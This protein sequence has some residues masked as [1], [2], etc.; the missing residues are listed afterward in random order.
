MKNIFLSRPNWIHP[1]YKEGLDNFINLLKSQDLNPRTIGTTDFPSK[2]PMDEVI[3]LLYQCEGIIVLGYPQIEMKSGFVKDSEIIPSIHLC[4]EWN[5]IET[6]LAYSLGL[7]LLIIHDIKITR[8]IFDRGVLN[9]FL[10]QKDFS[11]NAWGISPDVIGAITKWKT[12]LKAINK[13]IK[14]NVNNETPVLKWGCFKF[15]PDENLYCPFCYN[16]KGEKMLTSRIDGKNR[17][18]TSCSK[19]IAS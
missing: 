15:P 3:D 2:S 5:H 13:P 4:T 9:S 14:K 10:H 8:G 1:T 16:N 18:C 6:S 12:H 11:D 17:Q 19:I 7:P